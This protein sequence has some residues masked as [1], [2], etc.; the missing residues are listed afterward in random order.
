MIGSYRSRMILAFLVLVSLTRHSAEATGER[1][2]I[3]G[4][5]MGGTYVAASRGL[6][7]VGLN[8]GTLA[9]PDEGTV[10]FSL[11]PFGIH[12]GSDVIT[13]E[14]YNKYFTGIDTDS[15]RVARYL[16]DV[17]KQDILN[18]F[19]DGVG[20]T[21]LDAEALLFGLSLRVPKIGVFAFTVSEHIGAY[22]DIPQ[23]YA[24][25]IL[26]G[27]L[28]GRT[29]DFSTFGA[30]GLW[31]REYALSFGTVIPPMSILK[32]ITGGATLKLVRGYAYYEVD[33]FN[34]RL[35]TANDGVLTGDVHF[36]SRLAGA[37]L[38]DK[39]IGARYSLF[40]EAVGSGFGVDVGFAG[41]VNEMVTVG[42]S[43]TDI[44]SVVWNDHLEE[45]VIDTNI[46]VDDPL[47]T[48]QRDQIE[49]TLKGERRPGQPFS[50][51]L[52]TTLRMGAV[53][54]VHK[55]P[56]FSGAPGELIA[57]MDYTQGLVDVPGTTVRARVSLG[58]EY[59]FVPWLPIRGGVSLGGQ[60][61]FNYA[62]GFGLN[63]G[64]FDLD[65]ASEN[66]DMLF[67]PNSFSRASV[68]VGMQF[69][70]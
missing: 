62:F 36:H 23:D 9:L 63:F 67:N 42:L 40:P 27:N 68:A 47:S 51:S 14:M 3:A 60:D 38:P 41:V 4:L 57:A 19:E 64:V 69:R 53:L 45:M 50:R 5:G 61:H 65:L 26:H 54:A 1:T 35:A 6:N 29:L 2:N 46:V 70:I 20:R 43:V 59:R 11:I 7:A 16:T 15:G 24:T 48:P 49:R 66:A 21:M 25:F 28:P 32:T 18:R 34:T 58:V 52:P 13:Y 44:G 12:M 37:D 8:P 22:L 10:S 17:E 56:F 33:Q 55:L 30:R 39:G 31:T